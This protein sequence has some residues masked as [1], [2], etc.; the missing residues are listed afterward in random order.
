MKSKQYD[1]DKCKSEKM[2]SGT[3]GVSEVLRIFN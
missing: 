2:S 3:E 1:K